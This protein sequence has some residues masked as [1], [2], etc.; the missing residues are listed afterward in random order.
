MHCNRR[1]RT[2]TVSFVCPAV[3]HYEQVATSPD[4]VIGTRVCSFRRMP[5]YQDDLFK[6]IMYTVGRGVDGQ[7]KRGTHHVNE[8]RS[9]RGVKSRKGDQSSSAIKRCQSYR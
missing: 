7:R 1:A 9:Q 5:R 2:C 3:M 4:T 8:N 6:C